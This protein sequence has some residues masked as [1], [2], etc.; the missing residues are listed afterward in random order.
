MERRHPSSRRGGR[1]RS[2]RRLVGLAR[3]C[4]PAP[5]PSTGRRTGPTRLAMGAGSRISTRRHT[6][7]HHGSSC[8]ICQ[9]RARCV[10][11]SRSLLRSFP[12]SATLS[13]RPGSSVGSR[14][15]RGQLSLTARSPHPGRGKSP[16][17]WIRRPVACK[18]ATAWSPRR[19]PLGSE[20]RSS[21]CR[22]LRTPPQ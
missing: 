14:P 12:P 21:A 8:D 5:D 6:L 13:R 2:G 20:A 4:V 17:G 3:S 10:A 18:S 19:P 7:S 11:I 9:P 15:G 22:S 16:M 1:L